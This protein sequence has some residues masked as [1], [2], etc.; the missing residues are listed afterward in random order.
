MSSISE[1]WCGMFD[2]EC[3]GGEASFLCVLVEDLARGV[4]NNAPRA[5]VK[6]TSRATATATAAA[7]AAATGNVAGNSDGP[8][9]DDVGGGELC[10]VAPRSEVHLHSVYAHERYGGLHGFVQ[11]VSEDLHVR[12]RICTVAENHKRSSG[13]SCRNRSTEVTCSRNPECVFHI[14]RACNRRSTHPR[15]HTPLRGGGGGCALVVAG[16]CLKVGFHHG[17]GLVHE[18][19]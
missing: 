12:G 11:H 7:T 19:A 2:N 9:L 17:L 18:C 1:R 4:I 5:P 15:T 10:R 6:S 14:I 8:S 13:K 3:T 16:N